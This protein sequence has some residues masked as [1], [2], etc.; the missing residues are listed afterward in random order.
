MRYKTVLSAVALATLAT[1][2]PVLADGVAKQTSIKAGP[3][4]RSA[5][6]TGIRQPFRVSF[7]P[8]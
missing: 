7:K 2:T 3:L 6:I 5:V 8:T 4:S 1:T